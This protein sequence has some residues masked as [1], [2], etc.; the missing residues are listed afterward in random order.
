MKRSNSS[1]AYHAGSAVIAKHEYASW[2][3]GLLWCI[4]S[5]ALSHTAASQ[6]C[7]HA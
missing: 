5:Q 1:Q 7:K 6:I 3:L 4:C 2:Q